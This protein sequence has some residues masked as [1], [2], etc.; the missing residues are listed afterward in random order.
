M[1][2]LT[3]FKGLAQGP[4]TI[5]A[6]GRVHYTQPEA[7]LRLSDKTKLMSKSVI[8]LRLKY[9]TRKFHRRTIDVTDIF[10]ALLRPNIKNLSGEFFITFLNKSSAARLALEVWLQYNYLHSP[11]LEMKL[12]ATRLGSY[13]RHAGKIQQ[14][15][16]CLRRL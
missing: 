1:T 16:A 6:M 5:I 15:Y 14:L 11:E 3:A 8:N 7:P 4:L 13:Y 9:S 2:E 12:A 10:P